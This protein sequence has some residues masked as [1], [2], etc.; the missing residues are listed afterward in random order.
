MSRVRIC[1][2]VFQCLSSPTE[3]TCAHG[4]HKI[5][6]SRVL[7]AFLDSFNSDR[8]SFDLHNSTVV[9]IP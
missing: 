5:S 8:K 6:Y 1:D 9:F 7:R 2:C 4:E 3:D